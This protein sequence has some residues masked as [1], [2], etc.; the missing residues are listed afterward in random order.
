MCSILVYCLFC[1]VIDFEINLSLL[2]KLFFYITKKSWE[3]L[4]YLKNEK[5]FFFIIS[6]GLSLKQIKESFWQVR[7]GLSEIMYSFMFSWDHFCK[8]HIKWLD[9]IFFFFSRENYFSKKFVKLLLP[10]KFSVTRK[11]FFEKVC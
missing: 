8:Q 9:V 11:P 3:W 2:I 5:C 7:V 1:D 10:N 6:K 4:N